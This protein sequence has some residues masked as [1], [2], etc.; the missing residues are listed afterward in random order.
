MTSF[1]GLPT[2]KEQRMWNV[3][4]SVACLIISADFARKAFRV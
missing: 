1:E 2:Y 3:I 4:V